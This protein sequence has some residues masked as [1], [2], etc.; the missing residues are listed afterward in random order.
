MSK[1]WTETPPDPSEYA[2]YYGTYTR[3]VPR[4]NIL[5]IL[6][7]QLDETL[8]TLHGIPAERETYRYAPNKWSIRELVGHLVDTERL[9]SFRAMA[10]ARADPSP[11]P[12]MEQDDYVRAADFDRRPLKDLAD[13]FLHLR[14]ANVALFRSLDDEAAARIGTASGVQFTARSIPYIMAGHERHHLTIL[15]ERYL[16]G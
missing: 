5:H 13:E 16:S 6:E 12:N 14:K 9:F 8:D 4:G 3:Q 1:N 7:T 10:F 2:P 15:R 11:F